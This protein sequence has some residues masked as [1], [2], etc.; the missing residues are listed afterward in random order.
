[1]DVNCK[2]QDSKRERDLSISEHYDT[3]L[4]SSK[5][6]SPKF[7]TQ[8]FNPV[9]M[10]SSL[11]LRRSPKE[12][13]HLMS[14][15]LR[16]SNTVTPARSAT[17]AAAPHTPRRQT[18]LAPRGSNCL[19]PC[20]TP[21]INVSCQFGVHT[22]LRLHATAFS[23]GLILLRLQ[24]NSLL[25]GFT[26]KG[27]QRYPAFQFLSETAFKRPERE[28]ARSHA[29]GTNC[30]C[31]RTSVAIYAFRGDNRVEVTEERSEVPCLSAS[32]SVQDLLRVGGASGREGLRRTRPRWEKLERPLS[33]DISLLSSESRSSEEGEVTMGGALVHGVE[34]S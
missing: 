24:L 33:A 11:T 34:S 15:Y 25:V 4:P 31:G 29:S 19:R 6:A 21:P 17:R 12:S 18:L 22:A 1:M 27:D 16:F 30:E 23:V 3:P 13:S 32:L 10:S 9:L 20:N 8:P 5:S 26:S 14:S 2:T 28:N 7:S